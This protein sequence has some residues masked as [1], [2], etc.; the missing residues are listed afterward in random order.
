MS[1][2]IKKIPKRGE[3]WLIDYNY[4]PKKGKERELEIES[5]IKKIRPSLVVSNDIQNEFDEEIIVVPLSSKE[6]EKIRSYELLVEKSKESGLETDSKI[7]FNRLRNIE[8]DTR[9]G[10]ERIGIVS[11]EIMEKVKEKLK[12]VLELE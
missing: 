11:P 2:A 6:L 8:K 7:L 9:L 4:K 5:Y 12:L 3:I 1:K 10:E